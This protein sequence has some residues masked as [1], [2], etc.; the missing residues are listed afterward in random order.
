MIFGLKNKFR[1]NPKISNLIWSIRGLWGDT[2]S[3]VNER[4]YKPRTKHIIDHYLNEAVIKKLHIG[5]QSNMLAGWLNVDIYTPEGS[6]VAYM[7]ATKPFPFKDNTFDCIFS[8]HMIEHIYVGEA[9][10]MLKE[11]NRVLKPEGKIRIATPGLDKMLKLD[12]ANPLVKQYFAEVVLPS[13]S[14]RG[15]KVPMESSFLVNYITY[16]FG[17]KF[18]YSTDSLKFL[19]EQ[20]GFSVTG[21]YEP[22]QSDDVN[23]KG[24]EGHAKKSH[25]LCD[26]ETIN[27]EAVKYGHN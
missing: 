14:A 26:L 25:P 8:E 17:H 2:P 6:K 19:L 20:S 15:I 13:Y 5:A 3:V 11:C 10:C 7:D 16:N 21:V 1:N 27:V 4:Y 9:S 18:V 24:V 23:F 12:L 22:H